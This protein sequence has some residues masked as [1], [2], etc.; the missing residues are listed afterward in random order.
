MVAHMANLIWAL[1]DRSHAWAAM[2]WYGSVLC[3]QF[4]DLE[5]MNSIRKLML[6]RYMDY[7]G[8]TGP[9]YPLFPLQYFHFALFYP[10]GK[11]TIIL[12]LPYY[13]SSGIGVTFS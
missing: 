6:F 5:T 7:Q 4:L 1:L 13:S 8:C 3:T 12:Y 10:E 2:S 9:L 11:L